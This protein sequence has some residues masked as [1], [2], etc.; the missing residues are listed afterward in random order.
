MGKYYSFHSH[1]HLVAQSCTMNNSTVPNRT[2]I[3]NGKRCVR[4]YMQRAIILYVRTA[5]NDDWRCISAHDGVVPDARAFANGYVSYHHCAGG[6]KYIFFY[7]G[8]D[9]LIG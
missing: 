5:T 4:I 8:H 1:K 3:T 2:L 9:A 6:D 7:C